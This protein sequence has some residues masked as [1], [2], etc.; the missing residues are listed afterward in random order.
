MR[1]IASPL[2]AIAALVSIGGT[3]LAQGVIY[4]SGV[5]MVPLTVTVTDTSGDYVTGLTRA[6]FT[7]LEDG[8]P[9]HL[10]FF[11]AGTVPI[12]VVLV[13]DTSGSMMAD[14]PLVRTAARGLIER[15]RPGD[16]GAVLTANN[17]VTIPQP[18]TVSHADVAAAVD[19]V[20]ARGATALYDGVYI[21]L[22][23]IV[24]ERRDETGIRRQVLVLLSDGV[25]NASHVTMEQLTETV[26]RVGA[27]IYAIVMSGQSHGDPRVVRQ[28]DQAR[29]DMRAL[30]TE[31]GGRTFEVNHA[32]ELP[33]I[34]QSISDE[35]ASQYDLAY[36]PAERI[37]D[38]DFR[39]VTVRVRV[40]ARA[41]TR[42]GYVADANGTE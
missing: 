5:Q 30:A 41:R 2:A 3:A 42:S 27:S 25:D 23:E 10:A 11:S 7:I 33:A 8:V 31:S 9:Q 24:R 16:R 12:D 20:P 15:L 14:M 17:R 36:V 18:F 21:A 28:R 26:R 39:R 13:L 32:S 19:G 22:R 1:R 40:P 37:G 4:R 29:F 38:G 6:D 34:Y 35:L